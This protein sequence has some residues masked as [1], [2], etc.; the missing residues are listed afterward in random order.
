MRRTARVLSAIALAGA[1]LGAAASAASADPAAEVSPG[2][3]TPGGTVSISV[4]C[5]AFGGTPPEFIDASSQ[6]FEEGKVQLRR[7]AGD[8]GGVAGPAYR[9][10]ARIPPGGNADDG[11]DAM[12]PESDWGV[13]GACPVAP[14]SREKQWT[15]SYTVA[16]GTTAVSDT[17]ERPPT[18]QRGVGAGEGG[19]FTGSI[20]AL[21]AG[22]VLIAGAVGTAAYR[23]LHK[24]A[25][26]DK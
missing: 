16:R 14:G 25:P 8:D 6:G 1:A 21:I 26:A 9:G 20:P 11:T 22:S 24:G 7:V 18:V 19:A 2:S 5:D 23:L 12:G 4:T 15:A 3:V 17:V 10:T 13:D